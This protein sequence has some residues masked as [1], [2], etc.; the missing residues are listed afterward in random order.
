MHNFIRHQATASVLLLIAVITALFMANN[1]FFSSFYFHLK[2][3]PI[4][5][6]INA[7]FVSKPLVFWVNEVLLTLFFLM[8]GLEIKREF[9]VGELAEIKKSMVI[10]FASLGGMIFP[11]LTFFLFNH[12]GPYMSSWPIPMSTDTA[13]SLGI[14]MCFRK[15]LP[16]S[17]FT[18]LVGV[19]V[20]DDIVAI[21]II[22]ILYTQQL[23]LLPLLIDMGC[24]ALLI[25]INY[26][27]FKQR[28]LYFFLG[29][30]VWYFM[31][32]AG[33]QG[34]LS[35]ILVAFI[36]PAKPKKG[37]NQ[38]LTR[39]RS[40]LN[41]FEKRKQESK[42][43]LRDKTQ[44]LV[45]EKMQHVTREASTPLQQWESQLEAPITLFILPL[46][47]F[48]NSGIVI[49]ATTFHEMIFHQLTLAIILGLVIGKPVGV[50]LFVWLATRLK[51]ANLPRDVNFIDI[52]GV[53]CLMGIGFT[54]SIFVANMSLTNTH[55]LS[56]AKAAILLASV[57]SAALGTVYLLL[58]RPYLH[59]K[60]ATVP[61]H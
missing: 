19:A 30:F 43:I 42:L 5:L 37:S 61:N 22:A 56:L 16:S 2:D 50:S 34:T 32:K 47:A 58:L 18:F 45:L 39:I 8:V 35:G 29:I 31:E 4:G 27:G 53:S 59:K 26:L 9:L 38:F 41:T 49:K 23:H 10:V 46:F 12:H 54:I 20:L 33:I 13:F 17:I 36:I 3:A 21:I 25:L 40:L 55:E 48:I 6:H 11:T 14:L 15:K 28:S 24:L 1:H 51:L 44:H 57:L 52:V 7:F 60:L